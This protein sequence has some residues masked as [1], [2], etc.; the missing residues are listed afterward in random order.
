M[1]WF[2]IMFSL[3]NVLFHVLPRRTYIYTYIFHCCITESNSFCLWIERKVINK[4]HILLELGGYMTN[5]FCYCF[6]FILIYG[7]N[8]ECFSYSIIWNIYFHYNKCTKFE[9]KLNHDTLQRIVGTKNK[10]LKSCRAK[11]HGLMKKS[12]KIYAYKICEFTKL[13]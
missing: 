7:K 10:L 2:L 12:W 5:I 4:N 1:I 6:F 8:I 9:S 3:D 11:N 13:W